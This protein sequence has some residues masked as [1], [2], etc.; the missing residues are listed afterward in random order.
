MFSL[1]TQ[2][3]GR[4]GRADIPGR[5]LIQTTVP[6][7]PVLQLAAAQDY[8]AFYREEITFRKFGL[9]PPFCAFCVVG[10]VGDKEPEVLTAA[11]RFGKLLGEIAA[12][13]P[14]MPLR[15]LGPAPMNIV[16]L[17]SKY[18]YKLTLKCRNDAQ[19]R[20]VMRQTLDAYDKEK[21]PAK[22]SVI[23]DFNSDGDI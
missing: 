15:I 23:L 16:M 2:V 3:I 8:E 13:N 14:Q 10:F 18:R 9:Y 5:A 22:A 4:G 6:D 19:F 1:V 20:A 12:Q 7:H 11:V 21:L 17:N